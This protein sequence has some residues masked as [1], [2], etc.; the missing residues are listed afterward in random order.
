MP[1]ICTSGPP[2]LPRGQ[3]PRPRMGRAPHT[4]SA[5]SSICRF[6]WRGRRTDAALFVARWKTSQTPGL[7]DVIAL[8]DTRSPVHH[9]ERAVV[10][11]AELNPIGGTFIEVGDPFV[12]EV[13][14]AGIR[15]A[16]Q[17]PHVFQAMNVAKA[18]EHFC[19]A[20]FDRA[21]VEHGDPRVERRECRR[22]GRIYATVM[23]DQ[24]Y[25]NR[26]NEIVRAREREQWPPAGIPDVEESELSELQTDAGRPRILMRL[27]RF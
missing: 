23:R 27:L 5:R 17:L 14:R 10:G 6:A 21:V 16:V 24:V 11:R 15:R 18:R 19:R 20:A 2:D 22:V 3:R 7:S 25:I 4:H 1:R 12:L 13:F 8:P 9:P 26:S